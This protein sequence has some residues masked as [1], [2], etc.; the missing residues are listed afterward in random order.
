MRNRT[1]SLSTATKV[2]GLLVS[3]TAGVAAC[4]TD[5]VPAGVHVAPRAGAAGTGVA[6]AGEWGPR[7]AL[8]SSRTVPGEAEA[9]RRLRALE[10]SFK[11]RIG[12][13]ALDT[14][15][16]RTV[17][18]RSGE[19][20]PLLS[21]FKTLAAAAVLHRARTSDP[22]LMDR[23]V[24]WKRSDLKPNSPITEKHVDDGL[25]VARLCEAAITR[26]DNTAANMLLKQIGGPAGLTA[27]VRTLKDPVSRLDRW[28]TDLNRWSPKERRDTTTPASMA[29]DLRALTFG[30][31]LAAE[32]R[33]RL[34]G[35]LRANKTGDG[36]IRAGLPKT[37]IIGD[38]TGTATAYGAAN[39]VAVIRTSESAPPLIM[40]VYTTRLAADAPGDEKVIADTAAVLARALGR[41]P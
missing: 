38:K 25:T 23:V 32:D 7:S 3:I 11:G 36:R 35:W 9:H 17:A 24:R 12:A 6:D 10:A 8:A 20:F 1:G 33:A 30:D 14:A 31:A 28:E 21:T 19:R 27:Y 26:S 18:Y 39:D 13:Y 5:T 34:D 37:W 16:G 22:G 4:G 2:A 15:T 40:A 29:R 41:L